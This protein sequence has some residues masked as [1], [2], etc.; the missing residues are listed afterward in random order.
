M[1]DDILRNLD[2]VLKRLGSN[3]K[4]IVSKILPD[5]TLSLERRSIKLLSW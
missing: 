5:V 2:A 3:S 1:C 4:V